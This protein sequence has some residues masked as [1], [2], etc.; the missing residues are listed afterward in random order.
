MEAFVYDRAIDQETYVSQLDKLNQEIALVEAEIPGQSSGQ[1][2]VEQ[3][4]MFSE[5]TLLRRRAYGES[6]P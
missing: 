4:V 2:D 3:V 1:I 5:S 6:S